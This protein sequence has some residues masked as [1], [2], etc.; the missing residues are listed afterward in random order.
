MKFRRIFLVCIVVF[1]FYYTVLYGSITLEEN[2]EQAFIQKIKEIDGISRETQ[3]EEYATEEREFLQSN[4]KDDVLDETL[5][6]K[7][8]DCILYIPSISLEKVVYTGK[9]RAVHLENY[10]LITSAADMRYLNGGNYIIC[11][12]SS[13]IYG[14]SLNRMKE[15]KIGD[16]VIIWLSH[17][18]DKYYVSNISYEKMENTSKYCLQTESRQITILSCARY[19]GEDTYIVITCKPQ[20]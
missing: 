15:L 17:Q 6:L 16:E 2:R 20:N 3:I 18:M 5:L 14:H 9:N 4:K 12:H 7:A 13:R 1:L 8:Q 19:V 11:G 10:E